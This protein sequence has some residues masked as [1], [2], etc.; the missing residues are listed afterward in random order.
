VL[1]ETPESKGVRKLKDYPIKQSFG[2]MIQ[3]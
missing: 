3:E 1:R 2:L